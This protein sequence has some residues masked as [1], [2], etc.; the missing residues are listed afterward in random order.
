[1][2]GGQGPVKNLLID[3]GVKANALVGMKDRGKQR[4]KV[5]SGEKGGMTVKRIPSTKTEFGADG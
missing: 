5:L 2:R 1:M 3:V 4:L